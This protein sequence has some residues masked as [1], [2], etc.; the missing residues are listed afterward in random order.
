MAPSSVNGR[1]SKAKA[2]RAE[3]NTAKRGMAKQLHDVCGIAQRRPAARAEHFAWLSLS[4]REMDI[5]DLR[6]AIP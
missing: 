1:K 6:R 2:R 5:S 3:T 4:G